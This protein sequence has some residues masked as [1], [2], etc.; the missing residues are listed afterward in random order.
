MVTA[1]LGRGIALGY[2]MHWT[3]LVEADDP[4]T[5][6]FQSGMRVGERGMIGAK[7]AAQGAI[8]KIFHVVLYF[9][10]FF[11]FKINSAFWEGVLIWFPS[12]PKGDRNWEALRRL[13]MVYTSKRTDSAKGQ[14]TL[15]QAAPRMLLITPS[16]DEFRKSPRIRLHSKHMTC[17]LVYCSS[18][19]STRIV[20]RFWFLSRL[21]RTLIWN[22]IFTSLSARCTLGDLWQLFSF[23]IFL[24]CSERCPWKVPLPLSLFIFSSPFY[25]W[26]S[27]EADPWIK[28]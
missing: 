12:F 27:L 17:S 5:T 4:N 26:F 7:A 19:T 16:W 22:Y 13:G 28:S 6:E 20:I 14:H 10:R 25:N 15:C 2:S 8:R 23:F 18:K 1:L 11:Y 9:S 24:F 3:G 21:Q